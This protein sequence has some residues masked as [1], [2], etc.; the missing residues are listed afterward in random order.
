MTETGVMEIAAGMWRWERR[1][2]GLHAGEFGARTSYAVT[3]DGETLLIDPLVDGDDDPALGALDDLVRGRVRILV[4]MP[5][6]T[7]S[8]EPLWRR[9]RRAKAR[10]Y[11]HPDVATRLGDASGFQAVAGGDDVDGVARFHPIGSPPRSEQPIEISAHRALVF[12]DTIVETGDGALR[13]GTARW[14]ASAGAAGGASA[15]CRRSNAWP[16]SRSSTSSSRTA[17]PRSATAPRHCVARSNATP[18]SARSGERRQ[19]TSCPILARS[20][21][22]DL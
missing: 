7:R 20:S 1:P 3:V 2:R 14:T 12:G 9:Y 11:G 19:V 4:T 17:K 13:S 22:P 16:P 5:F 15:T 18:G 6:H 8:A 10:I 21:L